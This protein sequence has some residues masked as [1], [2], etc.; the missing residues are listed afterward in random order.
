MV[1][2]LVLQ[3]K[4]ASSQY[5]WPAIQHMNYSKISTQIHAGALQKE[6]SNTLKWTRA[7]QL[8]HDGNRNLYIKLQG[9][10]VESSSTEETL[11]HSRDSSVIPNKSELVK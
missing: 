9:V 5:K 2:A 11:F 6:G 7:R 1:D 8:Y 10:E 4:Y 3:S